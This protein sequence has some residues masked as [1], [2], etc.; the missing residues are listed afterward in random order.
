MNRKKLLLPSLLAVTLILS[1]WGYNGHII[2]GWNMTFNLPAEMAE[3][4]DWNTYL[5]QHSSDA[6]YRKGSDP[7]EGPK[8]Y[9]D[10]D[11]YTDFLETGRI[12]QDLDSLIDSYGTKFVDDQGYLP[13]ATLDA[14]DS[15]VSKLKSRDWEKA[16]F[17]AADLSHYV[18]DGFMP[19]HITRNYDGQFTGNKGIHSRFESDMINRFKDEITINITEVESIDNTKD[20]IFNYIYAN[21]VYV[22]SIMAADN[23]GKSVDS[24]TSSTAYL[25]AMW[26]FSKRFTQ[27]NFN[28]GTRA[29]SSLFYSA[30]VEAGKPLISTTSIDNPKTLYECGLGIYPNPVRD[31]AT[32]SFNSILN[33]S[34]QLSLLNTSG[35]MLKNISVEKTHQSEVELI[36]D[37]SNFQPGMYFLSLQNPAGSFTKAIFLAN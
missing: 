22:D 5:S 30:W 6:D 11:N 1:S 37:L 13:W 17:Y 33:Q 28:E 23:Y 31:M 16:K 19:L 27:I 21:Y 8:H 32:I 35:T 14:Y 36:W 2:I 26:E 25:D 34:Y 12:T 3:F 29:F 20:Y 9:I 10:I 4:V 24:N 18:A 15:L 7:T